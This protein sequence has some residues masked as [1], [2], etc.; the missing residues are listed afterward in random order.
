MAKLEVLS[1]QR[2]I[3]IKLEQ[4]LKEIKNG[5]TEQIEQYARDIQRRFSGVQ[6][7]LSLTIQAKYYAQ[8]RPYDT[9]IAEKVFAIPELMESISTNLE[10]LDLMRCYEVNRTFRDTIESSIKLQTCLF[11]RPD[12]TQRK[13]SFPL[14]T[15]YIRCYNQARV[16]IISRTGRTYNLG[17]RWKKMLVRQPPVHKMECRAECQSE[18]RPCLLNW[19]GASSKVL[20][21]EDGLT[22][23]ELFEAVQEM[24]EQHRIYCGSGSRGRVTVIF[25]GPKELRLL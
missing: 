6:Q 2:D 23:G 7:Y 20:T 15:K 12:P 13:A 3:N 1:D 8:H 11:L 9:Q 16:N 17:L 4:L 10:V 14:R 5:D 25:D 21:S 22:I 24:A 18:H 19:R